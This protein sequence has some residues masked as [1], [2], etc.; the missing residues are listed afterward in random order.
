MAVNG[1]MRGFF[2]LIIFTYKIQEEKKKHILHN[3]IKK[4]FLNPS[5]FF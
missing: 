5:L 3:T 4:H 2:N 1:V